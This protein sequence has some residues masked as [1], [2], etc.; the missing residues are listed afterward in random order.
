MPFGLPVRAVNDIIHGRNGWREII[1]NDQAFKQYRTQTKRQSRPPQLVCH[2]K[3]FGR[4][5]TKTTGPVRH[6]PQMVYAFC[7][8]RTA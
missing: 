4:S 7:M 1:A 8:T 6:N 5:K 2:K 3:L